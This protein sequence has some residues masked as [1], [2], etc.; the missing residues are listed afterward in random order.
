MRLLEITRLGS[1][2][3]IAFLMTLIMTGDGQKAFA[4]STATITINNY[5]SE[6]VWVAAVPGI[7]SGTITGGSDPG[8]IS[9]LG[10]WELDSNAVATVTV[11]DN[12]SG[13]FWG[14]TGCNFDP[15]TSV[16][17]P[18][19]VTVNNNQ[20][21]I[22]NCCDTGGC[23]NGSNFALDCAQ[24]GLPPA[25]LAEFTLASASGGQ[26]NYDVSL[27]DGG[28]VPVEIIPNSSD[29]DCSTNGNC[30]FTGNLPG[31]NSPTCATDSDCYPLFGFGYKWKCDPTLNECVN[32][33]FC[34]SPGCTATGGCAPVGLVQSDLPTSAWAG[35]NFAVTQ[36]ACPSSLVLNN[37]QNQGTS[38]VGCFA[39]Q[40]FCRQT[41]SQ[42]GD[43]GPP[44]TFNCGASGYCEQSQADPV[45]LGAACDASVAATATTAATTMG[46]LWA[47]TNA[48]AGS[49]FTTDTTD[50]NCC[51]CPPWAPGFTSSTVLGACVAGNNT[52]WQTNA[53]PDQAI[54]N[55]ASPTAYAFPYDDAIKLFA[56]QAPSSGVVNYTVT[57]CPNDSDG[58]AV[59]NSV[60]TDTDND[61]LP[62]TEE[63]GIMGLSQTGV[64]NA[65][66]LVG[67]ATDA[68]GD[69]IPNWLDLD[70]D[71]DGIPDHE[72]CGGT[73]D[74]NKDGEVDSKTDAD[75]DG[76]VDIFDVDQGGTPLVCPDTDGDGIP[77]KLD[78]NSDNQ[79][80]SD[81]VEEGGTDADGD[82]LPDT[83]ADANGDGLLDIFNPVTGTP[84]TIRDSDHDGIPN[85]LDAVN[86]GGGGCALAAPG[87]GTAS[88]LPLLFLPA[89]IL[90]RRSLRTYSKD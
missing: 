78:I 67:T 74:A 87:T 63:N 32:P 30:I 57:F 45:I 13:R 75:H 53:E 59:Q 19:N 71:N 17:D 73:D 56:C 76:L 23:M 39:P 12:W 60:D 54:F 62:N 14:R 64:H 29:Y 6:T 37:D 61:G 18:Q 27:V 58:D 51:G 15:S 5:C 90:L 85:H 9:T 79:G 65:A 2:I 25:T 3:I 88:L 48:N 70:S 28:N 83:T 55:S 82:G 52:A 43:C 7:T 35:S 38:Y 84:L 1:A 24:T 72:E 41:C 22:D 77:D 34:G 16:C 36:S 10:G 40:K 80:G 66:D 20:Y 50:P 49:C 89:L 42:D 11:P 68:D 4:Q 46:D 81:Y 47:C 44:Y 8:S 31:T 86:N 33:F 26:D 21:V 69:G